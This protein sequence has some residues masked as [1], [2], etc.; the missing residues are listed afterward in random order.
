M[1]IKSI[2]IFFS[3]S[4]LIFFMISWQNEPFLTKPIWTQQEDKSASFPMWNGPICISCLSTPETQENM[5]GLQEQ[6]FKIIVLNDEPLQIKYFDLTYEIYQIDN[7]NNILIYSQQIPYPEQ[8]LEPYYWYN[9]TAEIDF[10]NDQTPKGQYLIKINHSDQLTYSKSTSKDT[11]N[12]A[13][14]DKNVI[15][16]TKK[17]VIVH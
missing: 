5:N 12:M 6:H 13:L 11:Y 14:D 17:I 2:L 3:F 15:R 4:I 1:R 8:I 7:D 10:W 9:Y 16:Y